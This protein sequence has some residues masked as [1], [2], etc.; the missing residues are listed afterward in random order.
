MS[1]V[2]LSSLC[3]KKYSQVHPSFFQ[4]VNGHSFI[5]DAPPIPT[6]MNSILSCMQ[7][8]SCVVA[9]GK[10]ADVKNTEF[11][12]GLFHYRHAPNSHFWTNL[13]LRLSAQRFFNV[14][15]QHCKKNNT[16]DLSNTVHPSSP[17]HTIC[18]RCIFINVN[19]SNTKDLFKQGTPQTMFNQKHYCA[20]H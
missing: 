2:I 13:N 19:L 18:H 8:Y 16:I 11:S 14:F 17:N 12:S 15:F 10:F 20:Q 7:E 9:H 3:S 5:D 1:L 4:E 6:T